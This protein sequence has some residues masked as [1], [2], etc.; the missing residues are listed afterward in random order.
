VPAVAVRIQ[1]PPSRFEWGDAGI[2]AAGGV[3]LALFGVGGAL[4]VSQRRPRRTRD[5]TAQPN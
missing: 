3:A 5:R 1:T 4:V 2:G